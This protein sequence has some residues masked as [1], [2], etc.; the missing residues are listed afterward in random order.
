MWFDVSDVHSCEGEE[1]I[2]REEVQTKKSLA[3]I[4]TPSHTQINKQVQKFNVDIVIVIIERKIEIG[5]DYCMLFVMPHHP[6]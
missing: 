1:S 2:N 3:K 4:Q 6:V 5:Y